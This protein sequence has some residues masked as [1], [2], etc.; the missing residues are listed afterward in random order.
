MWLAFKKSTERTRS[1]LVAVQHLKSFGIDVFLNTLHLSI[2]LNFIHPKIRIATLDEH[3]HS[4]IIVYMWTLCKCG[5]QAIFSNWYLKLYNTII[6]NSLMKGFENGLSY[7]SSIASS[8]DMK[9]QKV[10]AKSLISV[11]SKLVFKY[12]FCNISWPIWSKPLAS[13]KLK[14]KLLK[15]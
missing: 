10:R 12:L 14:R 9:F 3:T 4:Y 6:S 5:C 11:F 8:Q 2:P 13:R 1:I 15:N 7:V